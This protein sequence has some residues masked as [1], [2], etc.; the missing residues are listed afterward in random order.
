MPDTQLSAS[1][2]ISHNPGNST[3]INISMLQTRKGRLKESKKLTPTHRDLNSVC[4]SPS[5][6]G[7]LCT[8]QCFHRS[9]EGPA[10]NCRGP[11]SGEGGSS[12]WKRA[13]G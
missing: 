4:L 12:V 5:P 2:T 9:W 10:D 8:E 13:L 3:V 6:T 1:E 11:G 7:A